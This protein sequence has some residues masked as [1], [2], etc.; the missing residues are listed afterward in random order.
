MGFQILMTKES[1][2][3]RF[4]K[5]IS[6]GRTTGSDGTSPELFSENLKD[7]IK[8][9][10]RKVD[11]FSYRFSPFKEILILKGKNSAPRVISIP[12]VRDRL[13]IDALR[14]HLTDTFREDLQPNESSIQAKVADLKQQ[15]A[16]SSYDCFLKFDVKNYYPSID[17]EILLAKVQAQISDKSVLSLLG[18]LL[19]RADS[20][21]AQGLSISNILSFIYLNNIDTEYNASST[22]KYYRFV[23]DILILCQQQDAEAIR[24]RLDQNM[25]AL[26]LDLH[27]VEVGG[28]SEI[29]HLQEDELQYL[30]FRFKGAEVSVRPSSVDKLRQRIINVF[31]DISLKKVFGQDDIDSLCQTLNL[32]ITGCIYDNK[33]YGWLFFFSHIN[34]LTLLHHLD[35]F[36]KKTF[37]NFK[38]KYDSTKVKSFVKTYYFMKGLDT[39]QLDPETYIP[40]FTTIKKSKKQT[41]TPAKS[42]QISGSPSTPSD[43]QAMLIELEQDIEIYP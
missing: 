24:H 31:S 37:Q 12:T 27:N 2:K 5:K 9:I 36:V 32:K 16:N 25:Q 8:T 7:E 39:D 18:K 43:L 19:R 26:K 22:L 34:D 21:V 40:K 10:Q 38:I 11:N 4:K 17:H 28:K 35:W 20:G 41:I 23:D 6:K 33:Q 30:G 3:K 29:G 13:L 15:I 1:L 42:T 14:E